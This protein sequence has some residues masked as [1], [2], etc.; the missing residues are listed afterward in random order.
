MV[1]PLLV[2]TEGPVA[3]GAMLGKYALDLEGG[4]RISQ[5]I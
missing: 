3:E 1:A 2:M 5:R 4:I